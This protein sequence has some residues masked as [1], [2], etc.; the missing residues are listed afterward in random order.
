MSVTQ[1]DRVWHRGDARVP[2]AHNE[3]LIGYEVQREWAW[4]ITCAFFFGGLGAGTFAVS[5]ADRLHTGMVVGVLIVGVLKTTAH[6]LFL[7]HPFR[8]WRAI[9]RWRT[10]WI[11]RGIIAITAFL[12]FG[13]LYVLPF[14]GLSVLRQGTSAHEVLGWL[15]VLSAV[16]VMVYDGFVLKTSRGIPVW[17][18]ILMPILGLAYGV[19]GGITV[20]LVVREIVGIETSRAA[21]EWLA[22][23]LVLVNLLLVAIYV[24]VIGS[25]GPTATVSVAQLLHGPMRVPFLF[26]GVGLGLGV[27]LVLSVLS[28]V[29]GS[30]T[31]LTIAAC[32]DLLGHFAI[33]FAI[34]RTGTYRPLRPVPEGQMTRG[35]A[36]GPALRT[37]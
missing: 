19:L 32:T 29:T 1:L 2:A 28:I 4:L 9:R 24:V 21:L 25:R 31:L 12:V 13:T 36:R 17:N 18:S 5:F 15:A 8:A 33:V 7:G 3:F 37:I 10:S 35:T 11:S 34:L 14:L 20:T 16:V 22:L 26:I 6:F 23:A 27:T 30:V